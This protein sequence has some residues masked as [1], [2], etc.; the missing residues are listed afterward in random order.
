MTIS[1]PLRIAFMGT[2]DFSVGV[3]AALVEAGHD[4]VAV[5]S[6]PPRKAGRG[7]DLKKS[8]VHEFAETKGIEV[9][10]PKSLKGEEEQQSF[11]DLDLDVAIVV[12]YGLLL[13]A[14]I[15]EAPRL[16]CLNL[17]ASLL[18]RWRGAAPIQRAIMAGDSETGVMVMQMDE[19][20]DTG[21][22]LGTA[23]IAITSDMTSSLLHDELAKFGAPLMVE[24]LAKLA[25]GEVTPAEQSEEGITYA[26]KIDKAEARIDWT[27]PAKELD[28]H[29][30]GLSPFPGAYFEMLRKG[31]PER[32]KV[33]WAEAVI[34]SGDPGTAIDDALTIACGEGA[35]RL[36]E[37]QRAGK[38]RATADEFLRGF[39]LAK[40]EKVG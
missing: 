8:P 12:A 40:G 25:A 24:T 32:V 31:K 7:M 6:Q 2:P 13:P 19:G 20:L 17:H 30:R 4:V 22:V 37:V 36:L 5:Y 38:G 27:R 3:L 21:P 28:C 18:P 29:I 33:L 35:L 34:G 26:K 16:G 15:L 14:A 9:R 23:R 1:K 10:T 11:A 39:P